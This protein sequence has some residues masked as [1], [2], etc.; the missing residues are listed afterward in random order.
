MLCSIVQR[1]LNDSVEGRLQKGMDLFFLYLDL[2]FDANGGI[3][4]LEFPAEP[5]TTL[6]DHGK[7]DRRRRSDVD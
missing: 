6:Q 1:F 4:L 7:Q 3:S 2:C 5:D